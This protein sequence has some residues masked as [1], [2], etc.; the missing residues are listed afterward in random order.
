MTMQDLLFHG[1]NGTRDP[2]L[3]A[4][5]EVAG[6]RTQGL[7]RKTASRVVRCFENP[8]L[9]L[10]SSLEVIGITFINGS[11]EGF[12]VDSVDSRWGGKAFTLR[13]GSFSDPRCS[14]TR[15][16]AIWDGADAGVCSVAGVCVRDG[17]SDLVDCMLGWNLR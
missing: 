8:H 2:H 12:R 1:I 4:N 10:K 13:S 17:A 14:L 16:N 3:S 15:Q 5:E 7:Q 11:L 9:F 6:V